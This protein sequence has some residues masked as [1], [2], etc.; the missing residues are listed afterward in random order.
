[1]KGNETKTKTKEQEKKEQMQYLKEL[2]KPKDKWK[3]GKVLMEL[4]KNFPHDAI[5]E[6][7][8]KEEFKDN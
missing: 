6:R 8:I 2:S 1:M 5:I 4:Q 3:R 7:M